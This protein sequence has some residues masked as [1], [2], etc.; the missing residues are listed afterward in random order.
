MVINYIVIEII[1]NKPVIKERRGYLLLQ[2]YYL[3]QKKDKE[4][5]EDGGTAA[6]V[7]ADPSSSELDEQVIKSVSKQMQ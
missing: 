5:V 1:Y 2:H 7:G 3:K 4:A 6:D